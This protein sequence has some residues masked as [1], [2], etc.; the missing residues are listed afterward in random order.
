MISGCGRRSAN[1]LGFLTWAGKQE[2]LR[3]LDVCF[4]LTFPYSEHF[5]HATLCSSVTL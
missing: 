4:F 3:P 1:G 5:H 2:K